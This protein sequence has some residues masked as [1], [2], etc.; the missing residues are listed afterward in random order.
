MGSLKITT[1]NAEWMA[2]MFPGSQNVFLE[3]NMKKKIPDVDVW[4]K[5]KA[6]YIKSLNPDILGIQEGPKTE[7]QMESFVQ[8]YLSDSEGNPLY[9]VYRT[10]DGPIPRSIYDKQYL[11][12]LIKR[13]HN[14]QVKNLKNN[15]KVKEF[16][17]GYWPVYYWGSV[18]EK[19]HRFWRRPLVTEI[20]IEGKT[21]KIIVVH[22]KSLLLKRGKNGP[23]NIRKNLQ[24]RQ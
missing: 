20:N 9:A 11:Y 22:T 5:R 3:K 1:W 2:N 8:K 15:P 4:A 23:K 21:L 24:K 10:A 17:N 19:R 6:N 14:F 16:F 18:K 13:N 7:D 12:L